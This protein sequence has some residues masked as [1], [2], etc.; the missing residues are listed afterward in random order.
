MEI[1]KNYRHIRNQHPQ[2]YRGRECRV[3]IKN[4]RFGTKNALCEYAIG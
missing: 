2:V 3:E 1:R 4:F